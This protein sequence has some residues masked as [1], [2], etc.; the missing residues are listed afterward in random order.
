MYFW[1]KKIKK[2]TKII[3]HMD[4]WKYGQILTI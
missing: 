4:L 3:I 2:Q 1:D